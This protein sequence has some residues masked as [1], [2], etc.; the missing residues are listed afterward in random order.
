MATPMSGVLAE[1][2]IDQRPVGDIAPVER[3]ARREFASA[4]HQAVQDHRV[5]PRIG[6]CR[7]DGAADVPGAPSDQDFHRPAASVAMGR[8]P[9]AD[10]RSVTAAAEA[11]D[12]PFA[13]G[14]YVDWGWVPDRPP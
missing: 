13:P 1:D 7:C 3:V 10:G 11:R 5:D 14:N 9:C 2:V 8:R 12:S 6:A 4:G